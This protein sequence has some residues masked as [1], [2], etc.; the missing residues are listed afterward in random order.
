MG[1]SIEGLDKLLK[2]PKGCGEQNM[3]VFAPNIYVMDYLTA[4]GQLNE[5]ISQK[6]KIF[7][8]SGM[9]LH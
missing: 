9:S 2:M 6:A 7:M 5:K 8:Q 4:T 1:P 3:V